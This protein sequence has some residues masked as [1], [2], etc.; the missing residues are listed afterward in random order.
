MN[1]TQRYYC[2]VD[3]TAQTKENEN[4]VNK[5]KDR[6]RELEGSLAS[7]ETQINGLNGRVESL[8]VSSLNDNQKRTQLQDRIDVLEKQ[9]KETQSSLPSSPSSPATIMGPAA[10]Q[11]LL[12]QTHQQVEELRE[13]QISLKKE[14]ALLR[15]KSQLMKEENTELKAQCSDLSSRE[16]ALQ[17]ANRLLRTKLITEE[18]RLMELSESA[19]TASVASVA[20]V[21]SIASIASVAGEMKE[22]EDPLVA[23]LRRQVASL[24]EVNQRLFESLKSFTHFKC[25]PVEGTEDVSGGAARDA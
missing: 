10:T 4:T 2:F 9:L 7:K 14:N 13:A 19:R 22:S 1:T 21:A 25:I 5:L 20:S 17:Q 11:S 8:L 6:I 15:S 18:G 3:V 23:D 12:S 24:R 16:A